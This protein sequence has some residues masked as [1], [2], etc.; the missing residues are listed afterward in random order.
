MAQRYDFEGIKKFGLRGINLALAT[1][2]W[3]AWAVKSA[4]APLLNFL[5]KELINWLA[6]RGLVILNIGAIYVKGQFDQAA[7]DKA[8]DAAI[9]AVESSK[10]KLTPEQIKAIDDE[11]I[12]AADRFLPYGKPR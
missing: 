8:I 11:V 10:G 12:K 9:K 5:I 1:T 7:F 6:N 4:F 2:S 3:G